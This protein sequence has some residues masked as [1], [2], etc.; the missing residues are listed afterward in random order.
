M[1]FTSIFAMQT[2]TFYS[3]LMIVNIARGGRF[4]V[5]ISVLWK[6]GNNLHLDTVL[7]SKASTKICAQEFQPNKSFLWDA[8]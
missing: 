8:A 3:Y 1:N 4:G 6:Y 5:K 7:L 2:P